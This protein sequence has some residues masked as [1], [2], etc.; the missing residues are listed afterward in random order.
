MSSNT[1]IGVQEWSW[2]MGDLMV[3][4]VTLLIYLPLSLIGVRLVKGAF[5]CK[6]DMRHTKGAKWLSLPCN[7]HVCVFEA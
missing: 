6:L 2:L 7:V 3:Q 1:C 4:G 5:K